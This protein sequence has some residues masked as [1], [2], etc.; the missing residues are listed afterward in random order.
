MAKL[1]GEGERDGAAP[2]WEY[3]PPDLCDLPAQYVHRRH[4]WY[5]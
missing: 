5:K 2:A 4:R 3:A 1:Y